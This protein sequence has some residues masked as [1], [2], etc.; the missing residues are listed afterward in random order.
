MSARGWG[1]CLWLCAFFGVSS[2]Q[3]STVKHQL[4]AEKSEK[5][6]F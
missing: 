5:R 1:H 6:C 2:V 3:N 4:T